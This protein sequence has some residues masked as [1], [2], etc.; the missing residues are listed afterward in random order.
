VLDSP[1]LVD[2]GKSFFTRAFFFHLR[3]KLV[4]SCALLDCGFRLLEMSSVVPAKPPQVSKKSYLDKV[5]GGVLRS[6]DG[7]DQYK[8]SYRTN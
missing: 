4:I 7:D 1:F 8:G 6:N 2:I 3:R 5:R